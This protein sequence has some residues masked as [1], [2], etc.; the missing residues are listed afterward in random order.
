MNKCIAKVSDIPAD[1]GLVVRL[2]DG[3]EIALFHCDGRVY[4]LNNSCPHMQGPLGEGEVTAGTVTCP[5]HGWQFDIKSG[6]CINMPG[7]SA[8]C[9]TV[10]VENGLVYLET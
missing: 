8:T 4:A 2:S 5:W 9:V 10:N 1:Q 3:N 7:E 6:D